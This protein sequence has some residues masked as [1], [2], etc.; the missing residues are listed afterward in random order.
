ML[1]I[2]EPGITT[3]Y[4]LS[5]SKGVRDGLMD[6]I[7][8]LLLPE[9]DPGALPPAGNH[10][11]EYVRGWY[12]GHMLRN[13][14]LFRNDE[15]V[16]GITDELSRDRRGIPTPPHENLGELLT[17]L[18]DS[19]PPLQG[20]RLPTKAVDQRLLGRM[21]GTYFRESLDGLVRPE[22]TAQETVSDP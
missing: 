22:S 7:G 1:H 10:R 13:S 9:G 19:E 6:D 16:K 4:R 14:R 2:P 18:Q 20:F 15:F 21:F 11:L 12:S 8:A 3:G 17:A 5:F